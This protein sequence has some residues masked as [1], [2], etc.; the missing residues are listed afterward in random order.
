MNFYPK[1]C[2]LC[3]SQVE[4]LSNAKIYGRKYGSGFC[5]RCTKCNA[6]V[7]T[8]IHKPKKAMGILADKEMREAKM[9][10]HTLFDSKWTNS[11]ERT[12]CYKR[13]AT[14]LGIEYENCHFG[15]FDIPTMT[16]A[17]ALI[18]KWE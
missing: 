11:K 3:G 15:F 8:Y 13:L 1:K 18:S 4:Y 7:G 6:Y 17:Y 2:N 5:Y 10:C 9:K 16:K 14:E 12:A